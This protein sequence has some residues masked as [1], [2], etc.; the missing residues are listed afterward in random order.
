MYI[1]GNH[2]KCKDCEY[3][4]FRDVPANEKLD[5]FNP[6]DGWCSKVVPRGYTGAGKENGKVYS[7]QMHCFR[8]ELKAEGEQECLITS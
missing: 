3:F 6:M 1:N 7:G 2:A 8:F 4:S 5:K